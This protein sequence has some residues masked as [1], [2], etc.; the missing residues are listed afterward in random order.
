MAA[1][2]LVRVWHGSSHDRQHLSD[3]PADDTAHAWTGTT[4]CGAEGD[5]TWI[6]PEQVDTGIACPD[7]VALAGLSP[8]LEG[9]HPGPV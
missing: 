2:A 6:V 5:L 7:C 4:V 1:T 8:P 3:P 9:D